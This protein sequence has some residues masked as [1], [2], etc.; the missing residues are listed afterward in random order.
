METGSNWLQSLAGL[1]PLRPDVALILGLF[2]MCLYLPSLLAALVD[3]RKPWAS[4]VLGIAG[5]LLIGSAWVRTP[6]GYRLQEIPEI[7]FQVIAP[8]FS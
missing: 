5:L 7:F 4:R 8:L 3:G 2:F 6:G 1:V